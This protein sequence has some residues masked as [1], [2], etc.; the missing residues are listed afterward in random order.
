[1]LSPSL[2][3]DDDCVSCEMQFRP[4]VMLVSIVRRF[5]EGF[6]RLALHDHKGEVSERVA[7]ATHELL[8]NAVK[9][10][11]SGETGLRIEVDQKPTPWDIRV[12]TWNR[13]SDEHAKL[14]RDQFKRFS[15][16]TKEEDLF[17]LYQKLM[18]EAVERGK[19][20]GLGLVRVR[21]EAEMSLALEIDEAQVVRVHAHTTMDPRPST[22]PSSSTT[23]T[24]EV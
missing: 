9:Y 14:L 23:P 6:Y 12:S 11:S 18:I 16:T 4:N 10:S 21:S 13:A 15:D 19:G 3:L 20:S 5:V 7:L 22:S 24:S 17:A 2:S 8:E 1:M